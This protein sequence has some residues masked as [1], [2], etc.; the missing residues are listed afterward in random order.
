MPRRA[1][2]LRPSPRELPIEIT[3]PSVTSSLRKAGK[4][5]DKLKPAPPRARGTVRISLPASVA[6]DPKAL[7]KSIATIVERLGCPRC[8]SGAD[9]FFV[10]ERDFVVDQK[11]AVTAAGPFPEPWRAANNANTYTVGLSSAV[12]NDI[13]KVFVAIDKAIDIIGP[14]PC[15]SGFDFHF[16][17][18]LRTIVV[19]EKLEAQRF[20]RAG[21]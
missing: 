21:F 2:I 3:R 18:E 10:N 19:N 9:C 17:D 7:K 5:A 12:R 1:R 14:H 8:F 11:F 15:I 4:M 13:D 16:Q 6:Y 20:D